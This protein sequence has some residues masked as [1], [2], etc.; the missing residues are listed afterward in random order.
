MKKNIKYDTK[1]YSTLEGNFTQIANDVF[2]IIE[3]PYQYT[4]YCYLCMRYNT[5]NQY[6]F[7]SIKTMVKDCNIGQTK[8]KSTLKELEDLGLIKK[9]QLKKENQSFANNIYYIFYPI[10][11]EEEELVQK[12]ISVE[13]VLKDISEGEKNYT[14][15][16]EIEDENDKE[17]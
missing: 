5:V 12:V 14:K 17:E 4:V 8:L 13:E 16:I 11:K 9:K 15:T 7:P 10:I 6:A 1:R 2:R 3:S